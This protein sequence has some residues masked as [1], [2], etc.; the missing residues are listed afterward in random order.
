MYED[1]NDSI[2]D[3]IIAELETKADLLFSFSDKIKN[4]DRM[5][6]IIQDAHKQKLGN[7]DGVS[8]AKALG[9]TNEYFMN[10][11]FKVNYESKIYQVYGK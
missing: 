7:I 2:V 6:D 5:L 11:I 9:D 4:Y 1:K 3:I 10:K 8:Y